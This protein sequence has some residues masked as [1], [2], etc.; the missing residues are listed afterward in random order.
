MQTGVEARGAGA[1][2][3]GREVV[4]GWGGAGLGFRRSQWRLGQGSGAEVVAGREGAGVKREERE[5]SGRWI[6]G[7]GAWVGVG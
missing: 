3:S 6:A 4:A 5:G 7:A 2:G 1:E